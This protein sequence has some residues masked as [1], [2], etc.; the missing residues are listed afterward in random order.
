MTTAFGCL[1]GFMVW[2]LAKYLVG[3]LYT[4]NQNERAVKSR[5]GRAQR[6]GTATTLDDPICEHLT[7]DQKERYAYPQV[8][9]IPPGGPYFKWPWE[10]IHKISIATETVNMA[11]DP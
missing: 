8:R 9:V 1:I 6:V 2:F 5:F 7:A 4:V 10:K 11:W 3:G